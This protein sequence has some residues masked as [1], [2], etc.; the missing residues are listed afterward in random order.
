[1]GPKNPKLEKAKRLKAAKL[2]AEAS[3]KVGPM[4][5]TWMEA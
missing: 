3:A 2:E 5:S 1:M 4:L